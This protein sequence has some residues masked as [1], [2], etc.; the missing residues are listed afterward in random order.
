MD[1]ADITTRNRITRALVLARL[2]RPEKALARFGKALGGKLGQAREG[3]GMPKKALARFGKALAGKLG[4][5]REGFGMPEKAL[6]RVGK[7]NTFE[8]AMS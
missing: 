7:D 1:I 6:S 2:G 4:Q 3:F 5:A 8:R